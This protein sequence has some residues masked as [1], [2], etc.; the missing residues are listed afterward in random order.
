[1]EY[2]EHRLKQIADDL[3]SVSRPS[4]LSA[5]NSSDLESFANCVRDIAAKFQKAD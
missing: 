4:E 5:N 1:M 2:I 3:E